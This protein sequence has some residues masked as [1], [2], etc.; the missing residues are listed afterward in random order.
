MKKNDLGADLLK[1]LKNRRAVVG[2]LG[3]GYV[4]LPLALRFAQAGLPVIG[5]D[6]DAQKVARLRAGK[7]YINYIPD[8]AIRA[9]R[10]K[11][12]EPTSDFARAAACDA[13]II[14]VPTPLNRSREPDLSFVVNT[15]EA[16]APYLKRGQ[17]VSLESTTWPGTTEEVIQPIVEKRGLKVGRD[18][19]LVFSPER[20]DPGNARFDTHNIPKLVGGV[21]E[22]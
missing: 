22:A 7:S 20:Q 15:A 14:C 21:T 19:F 16:I 11:G 13:L 8:Q 9:G 2:V 4:G 18:L 17:L 10:A 6:I 1:K 3:L 12:F 5:F